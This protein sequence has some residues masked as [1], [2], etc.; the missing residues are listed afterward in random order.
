MLSNMRFAYAEAER[1]QNDAREGDSPDA[2]IRTVIKLREMAQ[3][4]AKDAAPYVHPR[5][6]AIEHKGG[7]GSPLHAQ[8]RIILVDPPAR[9]A[10]SVTHRGPLP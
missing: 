4:A 2:K 5:L 9:L 3:A 6:S 10:D 7:D 1:W 8:V